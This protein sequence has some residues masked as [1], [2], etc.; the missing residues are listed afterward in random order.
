MSPGMYWA[1]IFLSD[2]SGA[3]PFAAPM[4]DVA[5]RAVLSVAWIVIFAEP[6]KLTPLIVRAVASFAAVSAAR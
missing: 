3:T 1:G 2:P 6:S 4:S 5:I